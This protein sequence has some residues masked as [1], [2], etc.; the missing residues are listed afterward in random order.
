MFVN[1][2]IPGSDE[3]IR[4]VTENGEED[5]NDTNWL[6][7]IQNTLSLMAPLN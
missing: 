1:E 5:A 3:C 7:V 4:K 6:L 2:W